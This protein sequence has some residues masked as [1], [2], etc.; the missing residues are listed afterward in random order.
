[1]RRTALFERHAEAGAKFTEFGGWEMPVQYKGL[2]KEHECVRQEAGLFDVSHMGEVEVRGPQALPYLQR[3]TSNDVAK[4]VPGRAQY[5]LITNERGGVVD[6]II[7][8][9]L[10][11]ER[12]LLCVNAA[13]ADKDF[14]WLTDKNDERAELLNRSSE[15][16]QVALQ[17]PQAM[18]LFAKLTGTSVEQLEDSG[19]RFF[20]VLELS[21]L[22]GVG[23]G[24]FIV[25]R[26]GYTGEDGVEIFCPNESVVALWDALVAFGAE[27]CGLGA[28]D[29]LRLEAC[30][31][32]HGHELG[33]DITALESGL[34]WVV[35][36]NKGDFIGR[37]VLLTQKESGA[38]RCLLGFEVSG[39]GIA[40]QG[41]PV[42]NASGKCIGEVTSGTKTPTV[43]KAIGLMLVDSSE[44]DEKSE[45]SAEVRSKLLPLKIVK[46]PFYKRQ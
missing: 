39:V 22:P 5:S 40:R 38:P 33:E 10:A 27:P 42:L 43:G 9:M 20:S 26:T 36:F 34:G 45:L 19:F 8:Y 24:E 37:D 16:S 13:N 21:E 2:T 32:L 11:P 35:K 3:V 30:L 17:G 12:Y 4:L 41:A 18:A 31:P 44:V 29:T 6:D 1:M 23:T 25:A 7:V 28:R 15:F 46:T 14:A